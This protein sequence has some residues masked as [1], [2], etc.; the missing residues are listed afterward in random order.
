M[1]RAILYKTLSKSHFSMLCCCWGGSSKVVALFGPLAS[2]RPVHG[3]L[4][5]QQLL[6]LKAARHCDSVAF[7]LKVFSSSQETLISLY[8]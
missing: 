8:S 1:V 3:L 4:V 2:V 6:W 7:Q 5:R